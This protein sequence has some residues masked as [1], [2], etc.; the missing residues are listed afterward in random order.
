MLARGAGHHRD[1]KSVAR[2]QADGKRGLAPCAA[3]QCSL[4]IGKPHIRRPAAPQE[5]I[6]DGR[7]VAALAAGGLD[8]VPGPEILEPEGVM[9][10]EL[11]H[12]SCHL[13]SQFV[14]YPACE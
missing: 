12:R 1:R 13:S 10:R 11:G 14:L 8:Q 9:R 2:P 6:V 7:A 4:E 5:F 3:A